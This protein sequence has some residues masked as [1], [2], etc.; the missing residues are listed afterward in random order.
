M[1][2][3]APTSYS[4]GLVAI[5]KEC[6]DSNMWRFIKKNTDTVSMTVVTTLCRQMGFTHA[7]PGLVITRQE[8]EE[9]YQYDYSYW[10]NMMLVRHL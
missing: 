1:D 4:M 7:N 8:A 6:K 2:P 3:H 10:K 9:L 5:R